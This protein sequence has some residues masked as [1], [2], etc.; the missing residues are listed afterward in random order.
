M[1]VFPLK[2]SRIVIL[3]ALLIIASGFVILAVSIIPT[4]K[5]EKSSEIRMKEGGFWVEQ[6][7][8]VE[9]G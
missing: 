8:D 5:D 4:E 3:S 7:P 2:G 6:F 1:R 9:F